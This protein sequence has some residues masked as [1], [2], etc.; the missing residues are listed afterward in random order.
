MLGQQW[1]DDWAAQYRD[2]DSLVKPAVQVPFADA[3][4]L[5]LAKAARCY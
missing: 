5:G 1:Q 4:F 3:L 2:L